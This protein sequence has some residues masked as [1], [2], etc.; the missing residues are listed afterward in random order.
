MEEGRVKG[1]VE[2]GMVEKGRWRRRVG[3]GG[4]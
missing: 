4:G 1:R 2:E 3:G